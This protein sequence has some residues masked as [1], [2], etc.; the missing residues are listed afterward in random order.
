MTVH[1][2]LVAEKQ[3]IWMTVYVCVEKKERKKERKKNLYK[4]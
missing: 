2:L 1:V 3:Q 4:F